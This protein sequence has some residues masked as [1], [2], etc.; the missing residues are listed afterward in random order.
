MNYFNENVLEEK[1]IKSAVNGQ[2]IRRKKAGF[3][4]WLALLFGVI[5]AA[6]QNDP[7][8][9][10]EPKPTE[11]PIR[12]TGPAP[13]YAPDIDPQM[14]A[15]IEQLQ[16]FNSPPIPQLSPVQARKLPTVKDA[17]ESLLK[18]YHI[19]PKP[20]MVDISQRV[21]PG[22]SPEGILVRIYT[23]KKGTGPFPVVVYYHGGG[24]VI[25]G[26]DVYE[27]SAKALSEKAEAIVVSVAYRQAP[28][29][30]F[31]AAH[32]DAFAAYRWVRENAA[33]INGNPAK[34]AVAGESAGGNLAAGVG[35]L[36]RERGVALPVHQVLVY[37]VANN[38]LTTPSYN[39]YANAQPLN[40]PLIEWFVDK[41]FNTPADGDNRLISLVDVADLK[42]LPSATIINAQID[43]LTS[44]GQQLADQLRAAGVPVAYQL[45]QGVTHEFFGAAAAV[46]KAGQAQDFAASQLRNAFK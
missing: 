8:K 46:D 13:A 31:P 28:E 15:V 16:G 42:G 27:P 26:P 5:L 7:I 9:N 45:Y 2:R 38:D 40:R 11:N 23:P 10:P 37:P 18:K 44:E 29:N 35:I 25:A 39:T 1:A 19:Q 32:E 17:V 24:W 34:V 12:P 3:S 36:A 30:K 41:Y 14:L 6:C 20:A 22:P 43:P 33:V 21:I 4:G